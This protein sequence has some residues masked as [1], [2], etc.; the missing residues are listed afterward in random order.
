[1]A[2]KYQISTQ[3]QLKLI[4]SVFGKEFFAIS[5]YEVQ[6]TFQNM[7]YGD[8]SLIEFGDYDVKID[9]SF[10]RKSDGITFENRLVPFTEIEQLYKQKEKELRKAMRA[11]K[12]EKFG[13][14][15]DEDCNRYNEKKKRLQDNI[16]ANNKDIKKLER[17]IY[18]RQHQIQECTIYGQKLQE[19]LDGLEW[20]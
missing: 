15:F 12:R 5:N 9:T 4:K 11:Y 13:W 14:P 3:E 20:E 19:Q 6:P 16:I 7:F 17:E 18:T 10:D 2:N 1:M 8:F